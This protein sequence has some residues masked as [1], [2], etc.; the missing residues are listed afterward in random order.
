MKSFF[1][2]G[3]FV[4]IAM[5]CKSRVRGGGFSSHMGGRGGRGGSS[6]PPNPFPPQSYPTLPYID[7]PTPIDYKRLM[8]LTIRIDD[9]TLMKLDTVQ[10]KL[11]AEYGNELKRSWVIRTALK[12]GLAELAKRRRKPKRCTREHTGPGLREG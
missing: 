4:A 9:E 5:T 10:T 3:I 11:E 2:Y 12:L 1:C 7:K 8:Q 6:L